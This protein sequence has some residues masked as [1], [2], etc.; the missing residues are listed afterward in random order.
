[1]WKKLREHLAES[2]VWR[3]VE[4]QVQLYEE[5]L[6]EPLLR[7]HSNVPYRCNAAQRPMPSACRKSWAR[8]FTSTPSTEPVWLSKNVSYHTGRTSGGGGERMREDERGR[9]QRRWPG[10]DSCW[11]LPR[12]RYEMEDEEEVMELSDIRYW[13]ALIRPNMRA[14]IC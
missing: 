14:F 8:R 7:W 13:L 12:P 5:W 10:V 2:E 6:R 4:K 1:M 9:Q 3:E 11:F